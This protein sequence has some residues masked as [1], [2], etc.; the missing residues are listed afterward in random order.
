MSAE[1]YASFVNVQVILRRGIEG[2]FAFLEQRHH[3]EHRHQLRPRRR[4]R[5]SSTVTGPLNPNLLRT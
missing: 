2:Y 5:P 1:R 3:R 4:G